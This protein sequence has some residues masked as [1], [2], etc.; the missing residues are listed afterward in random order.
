[1]T[2]S[3]ALDVVIGLVFIYLLYSLFAT[4]I[5]EIIATNLGLRAKNLREAISRMINDEDEEDERFSQLKELL[6]INP[7]KVTNSLIKNFYQHQEVGFLGRKASLNP[8][9]IKASNFS[10]VILDKIKA[11][12]QGE[13]ELEQLQSGLKKLSVSQVDMEDYVQEIDRIMG[14]QT[15]DYI[16]SIL[17]DC[18]YRIDDTTEQVLQF[19]SE[20]ENWFDRTMEQ[21]SEWYKQR[22]QKILLIIGFLI[23]WFFNADTF[24][25]IKK[26]SYDKDARDK[27]VEMASGYIENNRYKEYALITLDST[28][29]A[30]TTQYDSA[31]MATLKAYTIQAMKYNDR[32]DTLY[33]IKKSLESDMANAH[34]VLGLGAWLPDSVAIQKGQA[35]YPD[36]VEAPLADRVIKIEPHVVFAQI[37]W[38][39]KIQYM[40][41][42]LWSHPAGY[43]IT[44][45]AV[46]L[47]APFWFDLLSKLMKLRGTMTGK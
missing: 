42:L 39:Q 5:A 35:V 29:L 28:A 13:T 25:I 7:K 43:L 19:K 10:K 4:L 27:V 36:W 26:L 6:N 23:A 3:V 21:T 2:G 30:D 17:D 33:N 20:L 1:M 31:N 46:S 41:R 37:S 16:K 22:M 8:S 12:G 24:T 18:Q 34:S 44:A 40:L 9:I 38:F 45:L 15:A 14:P 32:L 47:G 11:L